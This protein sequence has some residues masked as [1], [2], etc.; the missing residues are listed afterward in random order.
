M[1]TYQPLL[2]PLRNP[3]LTGSIMSKIASIKAIEILDSRGNPPC[4]FRLYKL[5]HNGDG[6]SALWSLNGKI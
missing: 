4:K 3:L 2:R 6:C 5:R 1:E